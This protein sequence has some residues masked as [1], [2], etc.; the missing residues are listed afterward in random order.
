M[1][2]VGKRQVVVFFAF[3]YAIAW[4]MWLPLVLSRTGL[5]LIP[6]TIPIEYSIIGSY[7]PVAAA[8][9]TNWLFERNLRAFRL[10]PSWRRLLLGLITGPVL[11][12]LTFVIV[13]SLLL[14]K[15]CFRAWDWKVFSSYPVLMASNLTMA[16]PLG[17]EP[18]W[19]GYALPRLQAVLGPMTASLVVGCLWSAW[20]LPL[21][22]ITGWTSS[23]MIVFAL[24]FI[25]VSFLMT[26]GFNLS[27]SSV[28]VAIVMHSAFNSGSTLLNGFLKSAEVRKSLSG[29]VAIAASFLLVAGLIAVVTRGRFGQQ[30]F[31]DLTGHPADLPPKAAAGG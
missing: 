22:L 20:H 30:D 18:G 19:R 1:L 4:L 8:L 11:I 24:I 12:A 31:G 10:A 6:F 3:A 26:F 2:F 13:P 5:G 23:P 25:G 21:F 7:S 15:G 14:T 16:G 29:E 28:I 17:E 9:L 27:G